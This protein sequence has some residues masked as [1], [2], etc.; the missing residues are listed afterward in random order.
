MS[1]TILIADDEPT[2]T[3]LLT[4]ILEDAG[5]TVV[6]AYD[7]RQALDRIERDSLDLLITDN[8]MPRLSGLELIARMWE[9]PA[10]AVPTILMSAVRPPHPLPT[11]VVF[12][13]K[14]FDLDHLLATVASLL[15]VT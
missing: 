9:Q 15:T 6:R 13:P 14:P 8:M 7:G 2:I 12:L 1:A 10:L 3:E 4:L 5:Y 11:P